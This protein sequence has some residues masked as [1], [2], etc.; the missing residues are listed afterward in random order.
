MADKRSI[1]MF[2]GRFIL[3]DVVI[4]PKATASR[5]R[6]WPSQAS[7]GVHATLR[8]VGARN[9]SVFSPTAFGRPSPQESPGLWQ[10]AQDSVFDPERMGSQNKTRPSLALASE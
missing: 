6:K 1:S 8:R 5:L 2:S 9:A 10:V 3:P 4:G 7:F